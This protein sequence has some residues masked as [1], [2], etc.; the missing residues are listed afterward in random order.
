MQTQKIWLISGKQIERKMKFDIIAEDSLIN[1]VDT[2]YNIKYASFG[3]GFYDFV[4]QH[5]FIFSF[6]LL[7]PLFMF[8]N[9]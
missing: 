8:I 6:I 5:P 4:T 2:V 7:A 1:M 9:D 3:A